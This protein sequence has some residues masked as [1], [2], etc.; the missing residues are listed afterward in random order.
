[1]HHAGIIRILYWPTL[2]HGI[3]YCSVLSFLNFEMNLMARV[4][5]SLF[6]FSYL[7]NAVLLYLIF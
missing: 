6:W 5:V 2:L 1:M 7:T 4:I 3:S